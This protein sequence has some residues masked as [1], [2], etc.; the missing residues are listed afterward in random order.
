MSSQHKSRRSLSKKQPSTN[1][2]TATSSA[3]TTSA[4]TSSNQ[5]AGLAAYVERKKE[6]KQARSEWGKKLADRVKKGVYKTHRPLTKSQKAGLGKQQQS[7]KQTNRSNP[8]I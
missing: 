5:P 3:A 2:A 6:Q 4:S 8:L 1:E 7:I